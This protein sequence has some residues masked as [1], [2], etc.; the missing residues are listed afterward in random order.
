MIVQDVPDG[1]LGIA[2]ERQ[3]NIEGYARRRMQQAGADSVANDSAA[4]AKSGST[5]G[6]PQANDTDRAESRPR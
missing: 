5:N 3:R 4:E 6:K 1:A 2:R